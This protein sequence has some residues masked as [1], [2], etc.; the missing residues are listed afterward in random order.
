M[1]IPLF[2]VY[3]P[4]TIDKVMSEVL[5]SGYIAE[6]KY[7]RNFEKELMK[8]MN[9]ENLVCT[10]SC[11]HAIHLALKLAGVEP[12]DT[13]LTTPMTCIASSV[14]ITNIGARPVWVDVDPKHGMITSETLANAIHN[15]PGSVSPKIPKVVLYVC[16]GGD[17]GP[18][19]E[20]AEFCKSRDLTLIVDAAQAFGIGYEWLDEQYILGD[21][22]HGD[23]VCF[24]FQAIKHLTTGDGG[25][26]CVPE[27]EYKRAFNIKWFG[28]DR[29]GFRTP[30]GEIDWNSDVPEIGFKFHMNNIAGCIGQEQMRDPGFQE[31]MFKY[32][33]NDGKLSGR[34]GLWEILDRSW[35]GDTSSWVA[36]FSVP[37]PIRLQNKLLEKGIHASQM[38]SPIDIYSGFRGISVGDR[39]G[40]KGFMDKHLCLPCGWWVTD[41]ELDYIVDSV[42]EILNK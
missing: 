41:S 6:G 37:N 3:M 9:N 4:P 21:G 32:V 19:P 18:L 24:S 23:Y 22:G 31:R 28:I 26:L 16:W 38:H 36:T 29:E 8:Y 11:T 40:V 20:V 2:K 42:K 17:L 12:G 10:N 15:L 34:E 25:A 33:D 5:A 35:L 30:S 14:S 7:V 1:N 13:V 39:P 27:S